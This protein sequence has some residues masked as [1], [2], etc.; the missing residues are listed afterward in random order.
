[1][2]VCVYESTF[3]PYRLIMI[4]ILNDWYLPA[5]RD[6]ILESL[7]EYK[8]DLMAPQ[9]N[10]TTSQSIQGLKE[11]IYFFCRMSFPFC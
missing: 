11:N 8:S 1:M 2:C 3:L 5:N 6:F 10:M 7:I 4:I 9:A